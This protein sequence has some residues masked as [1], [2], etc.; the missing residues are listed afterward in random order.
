M[1]H[2][3]ADVPDD[4][5]LTKPLRSDLTAVT[6]QRFAV[7]VVAGDDAG[8]RVTSE[9]EEL[10]IGTARG[11]GLVLTDRSVSRHH[12][13]IATTAKGFRIRD[14]DS[15]NGVKLGGYKVFTAL[16]KSGASFRLG[17]TKLRFE[18]LD[19]HI[20][21]PVSPEQAFG[22]VLGRSAAM[23]RIF[24]LLPRVA[25]SDS[26]VLIEGETGTG[27]TL[28]ASAIHDE[29]PRVDGPFMVVDCGAV[30]G[31]LIESHLFGHAR[32]AFT[33]ATEER[34]GAFVA[35]R[36]GTVLLDEVGEL[37]LELQPKLLRVLEERVVTPVG[38]TKQ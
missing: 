24:A 5:Q 19:E 17:R 33:G 22:G 9:G 4:Q 11:N 26:T 31:T 32:G 25:A 3:F 7:E 18:I 36:G 8:A 27:K 12:C 2:R 15:T 13:V 37:P 29:S 28:L 34:D 35:A 6:Y 21:E 30:T 1:S 10:S 20:S 38:T 16:L 23:R 14:L